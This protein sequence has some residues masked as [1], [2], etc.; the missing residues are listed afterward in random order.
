MNASSPQKGKKATKRVIIGGD[1]CPI[2]ANESICIQA[3]S[4]AAS[5]DLRLDRAK[6]ASHLT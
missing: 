6:I 3:D 1:V 5:C 4:L 2:N